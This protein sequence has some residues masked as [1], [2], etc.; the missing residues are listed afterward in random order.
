MS[1]E[2][3][4]SALNEHK[5]SEEYNNFVNG[6]MDGDRVTAFLATDKGKEYAE[7]VLNPERDSQISKGI[8][9]W[10]KNHLSEEVEKEYKR[11]H[12]DI[13][14]KDSEIA[15]LRAQ[16]EEMQIANTRKDLTNKAMSFFNEKKL[17]PE[18]VDFFV[19]KD[20]ETT[21]ANLKKFEKVYS[22]SLNTAVESRMKD[23]S[24][25]PPAGKTEKEYSVDD[26]ANM[27]IDQI[28]EYYNSKNKK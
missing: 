19:G 26:L 14:P 2:E 4:I 13:D 11:L 12:P 20:E 28:N 16:V 24:Y 7:K 6:L 23:M 25:T 9:S 27:T 10:K 22:A 17:P 21:T 8:E 15:K 18:L 1:F 3:I 5:D